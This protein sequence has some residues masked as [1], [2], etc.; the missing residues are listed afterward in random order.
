MHA[1]LVHDRLIVDR[2]FSIS[3]LIKLIH[4]KGSV[5][6]MARM[7]KLCV[8]ARSWDCVYRG[9][10]LAVQGDFDIEFVGWRTRS[11]N[12]MWPSILVMMICWGPEFVGGSPR[13]VF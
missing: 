13:R 1:Q 4:G 7:V 11:S 5:G 8:S 6:A 3:W 2:S 12:E 9:G 10:D